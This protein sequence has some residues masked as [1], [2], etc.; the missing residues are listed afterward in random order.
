MRDF[1]CGF[2]AGALDRR[3]KSA[4]IQYHYRSTARIAHR[5][6]EASRLRRS[7]VMEPAHSHPCGAQIRL[8]IN[9]CLFFQS[10]VQ[11][12]QNASEV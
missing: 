8:S 10:V 2:A 3:A 12:L 4:V 1:I 9:H 6:N 5:T 11:R 7:F